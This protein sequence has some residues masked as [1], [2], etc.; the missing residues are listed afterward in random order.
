MHSLIQSCPYI[1]KVPELSD[2]S[3][4]LLCE[5]QFTPVFLLETNGQSWAI[6]LPRPNTSDN[7]SWIFGS[8]MLGDIGSGKSHGIIPV[9]VP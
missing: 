3:L 7:F 5:I 2:D 4:L 1:G 9:I 6:I 8:R